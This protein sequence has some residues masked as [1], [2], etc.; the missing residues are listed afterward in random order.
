MVTF[1][2]P[3]CFWKQYMDDSCTALMLP[4]DMVERFHNQ[5]NCIEACIQFAV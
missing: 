4:Q 5:L 2:S 3:L 1:H